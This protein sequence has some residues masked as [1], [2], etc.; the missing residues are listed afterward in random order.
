MSASTRIALRND[1]LIRQK[2]SGKAAPATSSRLTPREKYFS[3]EEI[4]KRVALES[5]F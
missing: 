4:H 1:L 2:T 3:M 5:I